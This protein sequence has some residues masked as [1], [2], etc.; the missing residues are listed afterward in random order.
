MPNERVKVNGGIMA[1]LL[2]E[3][4]AELQ[5]R[6]L[7]RRPDVVNL[8]NEALVQDRIEGIGRI[9]SEEVAAGMFTVTME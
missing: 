2:Q 3:E 5:I 9:A 7:I 8:A 4:C 1:E 6:D